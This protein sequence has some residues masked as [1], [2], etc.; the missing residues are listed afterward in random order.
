MNNEHNKLNEIITH[1]DSFQFT[2]A[3]KEAGNRIRQQ[4]IENSKKETPK[5]FINEKFGGLDYV[6]DEYMEMMA[7]EQIPGWSWE[8][9]GC[10]PIPNN[11]GKIIG[12]TLWGTLTCFHE[13]LLRKISG[14]GGKY[15][16]LSKESGTPINFGND[17]KSESTNALKKAIQRTLNICADVYRK[18]KFFL[19]EE[20]DKYRQYL[21]KN[22][23]DFLDREL[24]KISVG[25]VNMQRDM[26]ASLLKRIKSKV[27]INKETKNDEKDEASR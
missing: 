26:Y 8:I 22:V 24:H 16:T 3:I 11:D 1:I 9:N 27:N 4:Q 17:F 19:I 15:W 12:F 6:D 25:D 5:E 7:N 2:D 20:I 13:G 18:D 21:D 10:L 14:E 23:I